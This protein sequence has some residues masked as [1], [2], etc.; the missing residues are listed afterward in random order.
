M[1]WCAVPSCFDW[2]RYF[3]R[4]RICLPAVVRMCW[5]QWRVW[6]SYRYLYTYAILPIARVLSSSCSSRSSHSKTLLGELA[7]N[8]SFLSGA[9]SSSHE[10]LL[11]STPSLYLSGFLST[12]SKD[13][14]LFRTDNF[15]F[16]FWLLQYGISY[17]SVSSCRSFAW[18]QSI[19]VPVWRHVEG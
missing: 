16:T 1:R 15:L 6:P 7:T 19:V 5:R 18:L 14:A 4:E 11:A 8:V 3:L 13:V 12:R 10:T 9:A 2:C 17:T